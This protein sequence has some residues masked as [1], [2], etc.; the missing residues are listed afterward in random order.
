MK[1]VKVLIPIVAMVSVLAMF[2]WSYVAHSWQY[3]WLAV[4]VGGIIIVALSMIAKN[5][6]EK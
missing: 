5:R 6:G 2:I 1:N 3:S 4:F